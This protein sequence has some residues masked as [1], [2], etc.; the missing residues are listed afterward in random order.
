[1][2]EWVGLPFSRESSRPR[3]W[4][5]SPLSQSDS[6]PLE[7]PGSFLIFIKSEFPR[8]GK[9]SSFESHFNTLDSSSNML[10]V[11]KIWKAPAEG[12]GV[13]QQSGAVWCPLVW[14][15]FSGLQGE[16]SPALMSHLPLQEGR[17]LEAAGSQCSD[18]LYFLSRVNSHFRRYILHLPFFFLYYSNEEKEINQGLLFN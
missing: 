17:G 8:G 13:W 11:R 4:T 2:L 10:P 1:M 7:P 5:G 14:D 3:N 16:N 6:S 18:R 15:K 12:D 9:H